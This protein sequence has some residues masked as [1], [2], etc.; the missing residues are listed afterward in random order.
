M[1]Y[2]Y[3]FCLVFSPFRKKIISFSYDTTGKKEEKNYIRFSQFF[4]PPHR[5]SRWYFLGNP[6]KTHTLSH[7]HTFYFVTALF[8]WRLLNFPALTSTRSTSYVHCR[9]RRAL[10]FVY[11]IVCYFIFFLP[12]IGNAINQNWA[13]MCNEILRYKKKSE[14]D[15]V[16][17]CIDACLRS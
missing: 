1:I 10:A 17:V 4:S 3:I 11:P 9:V 14:R 6:S 13:H 12:S 16:F 2:Y 8:V 15:R 7:S 5:C